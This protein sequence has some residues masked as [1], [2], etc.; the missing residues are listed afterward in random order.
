ML[1]SGGDADRARRLRILL[2]LPLPPGRVPRVPDVDDFALPPS[3]PW[4]AATSP[5]TT[6]SSSCY[7]WPSSTSKTNEP[8]SAPPAKPKSGKGHD[9]PVRL[10]EGQRTMGWREALNEYGLVTEVL[11]YTA[12]G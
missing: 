8:A 9:Q 3:T 6:P 7:G 2:R 4:A 12:C 5:P 10:I 1:N 11:S